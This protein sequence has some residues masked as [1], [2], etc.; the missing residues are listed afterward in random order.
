MLGT[1]WYRRGTS[2]W[3]RRAWVVVFLLAMTCLVGA[4]TVGIAMGAIGSGLPAWA[5]VP[6]VV[7]LGAASSWHSAS[8]W[9]G[10]GGRTSPRGRFGGTVGYAMSGL[11]GV[12]AVVM[13]VCVPIAFGLFPVLLWQW[14]RPLAPGEW[15][16]RRRSELLRC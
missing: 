10:E 11:G 4:M 6:V 16:A 5:V 3:L 13:V 12:G 7:L 1:S 14:C 15:E 2:Y 8:A 9:T